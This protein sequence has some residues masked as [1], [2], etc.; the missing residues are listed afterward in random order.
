MSSHFYDHQLGKKGKKKKKGKPD[1][2]VTYKERRSAGLANDSMLII[3]I[4]LG[5]IAPRVGLVRVALNEDPLAL[6]PGL[7][8]HVQSPILLQS[9]RGPRVLAVLGLEGRWEG[10]DLVPAS[11]VPLQI[12]SLHDSRLAVELVKGIESKVRSP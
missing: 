11:C 4:K 2:K 1:K 12:E 8:Q 9:V 7:V 6:D 10:R 5:L 3:S